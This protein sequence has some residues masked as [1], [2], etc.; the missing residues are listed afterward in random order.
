M[1]V[2]IEAT[3]ATMDVL[4]SRVRVV[5]AAIEKAVASL[6]EVIASIS[7]FISIGGVSLSA[8]APDHA[9]SERRGAFV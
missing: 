3:V 9:L 6:G 7:R 8:V 2:E 4:V 5:I 1:N